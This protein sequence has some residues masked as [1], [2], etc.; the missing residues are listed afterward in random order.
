[1]KRQILFF[2]ASILVFLGNNYCLAAAVPDIKL[3]KKVTFIFFPR[4][5]KEM[6]CPKRH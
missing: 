1:M 4:S 5:L 6:F 2:M 3:E